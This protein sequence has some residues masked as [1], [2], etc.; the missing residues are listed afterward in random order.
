MR[1]LA[2][3][4]ASADVRRPKASGAAVA[5]LRSL[6]SQALHQKGV[7]AAIARLVGVVF[8]LKPMRIYMSSIKSLISA[9]QPLTAHISPDQIW[10]S[11][12]RARAGRQ[13]AHFF[14]SLEPRGSFAA[15]HLRVEPIS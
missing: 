13:R 8:W 4:E 14:V 7:E 3:R 9:R 10:I 6:G 15:P 5:E 12:A 2:C 11:I 1:L